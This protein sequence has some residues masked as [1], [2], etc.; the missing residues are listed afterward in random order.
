[1]TNPTPQDAKQMEYGDMVAMFVGEFDPPTMDHVRAVEALLARPEIKHVWICPIST[2][3]DQNHVAH[4][5]NM[6]TIFCMDF[7]SSGRQLSCC[8][9]MLERKITTFKEAIEWARST[10]PAYAFRLATVAPEVAGDVESTY[11]VTLGVSGAVAPEGTSVL[12][13]ENYVS[14]PK[15]LKTRI[16]SGIDESRNFVQPIWR[17]IM[18]HILYRK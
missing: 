16:R 7:S 1:M 15:D 8:T 9:A 18:K 17:Y 13:L 4:V 6:A 2:S 11:F 10:F 12:A 3:K 5:R 14:V